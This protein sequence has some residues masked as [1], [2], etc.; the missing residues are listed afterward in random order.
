MAH[1]PSLKKNHQ[2]ARKKGM[3]EE[4]REGRKE[5]REK[6]RNDEPLFQKKRYS[7]FMF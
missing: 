6:K 5:Q 4:Q 7:E 1:C 2:V 3:E